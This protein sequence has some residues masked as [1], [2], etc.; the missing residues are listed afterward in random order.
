MNAF[1]PLLGL[2]A[3][4][5]IGLGFAWVVRVE[6]SLG[7]RWWYVVLTLGLALAIVSIFIPS[8]FLSGL[9]GAAGASLAWGSTELAA[10]AE[11]V[12]A[13]WYPTNPKAKRPP[14]LW[15]LFSKISPPRL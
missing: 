7:W 4:A 1:G 15:R 10:Q 11:R 5:L 14:P 6:Y 3:L 12:R 13:G 9:A 2:A 8:P